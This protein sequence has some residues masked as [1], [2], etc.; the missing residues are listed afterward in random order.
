MR[1][2]QLDI[3]Y[4]NWEVSRILIASNADDENIRNHAAYH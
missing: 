1:E 4:S 3:A 2:T